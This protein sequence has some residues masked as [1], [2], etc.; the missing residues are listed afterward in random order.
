MFQTATI[1]FYISLNAEKNNP[2][3]RL[4]NLEKY[5]WINNIII[6]SLTEKR[7]DMSRN[8]K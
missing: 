7:N 8:T 2:P 1:F 4:Y 3:Q 6:P 5:D